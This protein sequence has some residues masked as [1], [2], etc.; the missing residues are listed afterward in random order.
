MTDQVSRPDV[1][2]MQLRGL[3]ERMANECSAPMELWQEFSAAVLVA[4]D[5]LAALPP[6]TTAG[7]EWQPIA[8]APQD[9]KAI[10]VY[11]RSD[12]HTSELQSLMRNSSAVFCFNQKNIHINRTTCNNTC[13]LY[14]I[15]P[16]RY[17]RL[18]Y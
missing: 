11:A 12:E 5:K 3:L 10:L 15:L 16:Y 8:T 14:L 18:I 4:A 17:Q 13:S 6:A 9:G 2:A 1:L 7:E